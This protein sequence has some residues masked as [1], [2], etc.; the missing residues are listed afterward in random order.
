MLNVNIPIVPNHTAINFEMEN[1][2]LSLTCLLAFGPSV[3]CLRRLLTSYNFCMNCR[4][5]SI[6]Q[7]MKMIYIYI[8]MT[9][10]I[11][12]GASDIDINIFP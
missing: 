3:K 12:T 8:N 7:T 6:L 10:L 9:C 5:L 2:Q 1:F 11:H 4:F